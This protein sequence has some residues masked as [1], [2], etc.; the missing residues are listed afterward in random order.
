MTSEDLWNRVDLSAVP[1][2]CPHCDEAIAPRLSLSGAHI[3]ADCPACGRYIK[4]VR[5]N[6]PEDER[7]KYDRLKAMRQT[8]N[9]GGGW[10]R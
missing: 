2:V 1:D 4:F 9:G 3:R 8:Q 7:A 10:H 5:Q 6:L